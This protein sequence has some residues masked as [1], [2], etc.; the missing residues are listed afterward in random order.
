MKKLLFKAVVLLMMLFGAVGAYAKE[1]SKVLYVGTN[2][3]FQPFEY[4]EN[5]KIVGFDVELMEALADEL[6]KKVEWKNISFD[7]LLPA[8]QSKKL[9]VIIAGMSATEDRKKFV[10]FSET[11]Y[12][13]N[14]MILV[15]KEKPAVDS[16]DNLSGHDVGVFLD[17]QEISQ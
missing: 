3:E 6:G 7:G 17:T 4:L 15:Q 10:N 16:F 11:Y 2:A 13:S 1:V 12:T 8:L 5:G 9:D 14:Q